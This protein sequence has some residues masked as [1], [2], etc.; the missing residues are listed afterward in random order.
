ME[1]VHA[2]DGEFTGVKGL[3]DE[4]RLQDYIQGQI[5]QAIAK[6]K[7]ASFQDVLMCILTVFLG[8]IAYADAKTIES[9]LY[10]AIDVIQRLQ[11]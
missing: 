10:L 11:G 2:E 3:P 4:M 8:I 9:F 7:Q 6:V 5:Q 1:K